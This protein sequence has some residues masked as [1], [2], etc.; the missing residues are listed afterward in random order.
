LTATA[1]SGDVSGGIV[2]NEFFS[3]ALLGIPA[4]IVGGILC[5]LVMV[6][7]LPRK[8]CP[9]CGALLPRLRNYW[10]TRGV[11]RRCRAC[12]CGVDVKGRKVEE[13]RRYS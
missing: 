1:R 2:V 12:G 3:G 8:K 7:L 10:D 4:G 9:D 6:L 5:A 13:S 11:M